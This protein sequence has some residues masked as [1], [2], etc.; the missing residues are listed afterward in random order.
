VPCR[1]RGITANRLS[2]VGYGEMSPARHEVSPQD[3]NS[4]AAKANMHVLFE[5]IVK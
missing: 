5:I 1:R 3:I 2:I 4:K